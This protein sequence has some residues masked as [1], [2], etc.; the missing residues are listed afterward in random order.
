MNRLNSVRLCVAAS[1]LLALGACD[2]V[3]GTYNFVAGNGEQPG[4]NDDTVRR[5][6]LT[7]PPDYNLRPPATGGPV[8]DISPSVV[9][10]S[11]VFGLDKEAGNGAVQRRGGLSLGESALLQHAGATRP[12]FAVRNKVD[13]ETTAQTQ[14]EQ[15]FTNALLNPPPEQK[16]DT[17]FF[18]SVFSSNSDQKPAIDRK[19]ES[20]S[21][22]SFLG[23]LF[24][25]F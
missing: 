6:P 22:G 11:A 21:S 23:G 14:E 13:A 5:P 18:D 19:G 8:A 12:N 10:R 1:A 16:K 3:R 7:L 15:G 17:G 9:A 4:V 20:S 25:W 24:D 2:T